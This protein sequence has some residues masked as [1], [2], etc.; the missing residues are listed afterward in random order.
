MA[1]MKTDNITKLESIDTAL[2]I[3]GFNFKKQHVDLITDVFEIVQKKGGDAN[4]RDIIHLV[5]LNR[6]KYEVKQ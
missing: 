3:A 4:L 1:T 6:I 2:K 5:E